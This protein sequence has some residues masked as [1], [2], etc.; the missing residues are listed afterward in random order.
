MGARCAWIILVSAPLVRSRGDDVPQLALRRLGDGALAGIGAFTL[1]GIAAQLARPDLDWVRAPM[2]FYLLGDAGRWLQAGYFALA[3]ALS[4]LA[5]GWYRALRPGARS[6]APALLFALG[7]GALAVT[8]VARTGTDGPPASFAAWLHVVAAQAAF[9][10]TA[11]AMLLQAWRLRRD[12]RW[13]PDF[14]ALFVLAWIAFAGLWA[15]ALWRDG[16]R[17]LTQKAE[18]ALIVAWLALA[19]WRLRRGP[20]A[21][22]RPSG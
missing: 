1:A 10:C 9:L 13:R 17:G 19:A 14:A 18:I 5:V 12:P 2:S 22:A 21:M 15:Q 4:L 20:A 16:P 11:T 8:A 6:A 3:I 7:G